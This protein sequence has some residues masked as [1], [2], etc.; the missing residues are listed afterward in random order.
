MMLLQQVVEGWPGHAQE[1]GGPRQVPARYGEGLPGGL[2][3]SSLPRSAQIQM[4]RIGVRILEGQHPVINTEMEALPPITSANLDSWWK[5]C[6]TPTNA[7]TFPV[8][9]TD[10]LPESILNQF[11]TNGKSTAPYNYAT[12]SLPPC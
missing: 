7:S 6:I 12:A 3:L 1:L 9:P 2:R 11:F 5:A 8:P 4:F 10:P